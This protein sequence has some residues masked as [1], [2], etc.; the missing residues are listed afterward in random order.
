MMEPSMAKTTNPLWELKQSGQSIWLDYIRRGLI[1]SG[2]LR[3][4]IAGHN[5]RAGT[6]RHLLERCY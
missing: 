2:E 5:V 3:A 1:T 6:S 4:L